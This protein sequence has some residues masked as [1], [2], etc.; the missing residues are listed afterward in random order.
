MTFFR[1]KRKESPQQVTYLMRKNTYYCNLFITL[2][3]LHP[4]SRI[5]QS[6][7]SLKCEWN[8][9]SVMLTP[10][11]ERK[12]SWW[13]DALQNI[14]QRAFPISDKTTLKPIKSQ[15]RG[16][17]RREEKKESGRLVGQLERRR[18]EFGCF[19]LQTREFARGV[20]EK[21]DF[22]SINRSTSFQW[23]P[24]CLPR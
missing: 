4:S 11:Y 19:L 1:R 20:P 22:I 17:E 13:I 15:K 12:G 7:C 14:I 9:C 21:R 8:P 23:F 18:E 6:L 10:L 16:E 24:Q 2:C 3:R 5:P